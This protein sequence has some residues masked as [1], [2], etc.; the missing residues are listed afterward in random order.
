MTTTHLNIRCQLNVNRPT[1]SI[2]LP[3]SLSVHSNMSLS[4][5]L[6]RLATQAPVT[7]PS[8]DHLTLEELAT[9][10]IAFGQKYKGHQHQDTWQDQEWIQFMVSRYQNSSKEEH[11]RFLKYVELQVTAIEQ[12][13]VTAPISSQTV[14]V[15]KAK[16]K[17]KPMAK[18]I[19]TASGTSSPAGESG[20]DMAS[21]M[22]EPPTM[23]Q[24]PMPMTK[25]MAA[26]Q[27]RLLNM[28]NAMTR[29][30][31]YMENKENIMNHM[32]EEEEDW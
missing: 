6:R 31:R 25:D 14:I 4:Q 17:V 27:Q 3:R 24:V 10:T 7:L 12:G 20:W 9:E 19:A 23:N 1:R 2:R 15:P 22:Y 30:I 5:I 26:V 13:L 8:L 28:E 11:R 32:P 18:S 29:V 16:P 21:E